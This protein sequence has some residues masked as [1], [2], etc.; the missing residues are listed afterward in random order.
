MPREL[1]S[2]TDFL[3]NHARNIQLNGWPNSKKYQD[4]QDV[5]ITKHNIYIYIYAKFYASWVEMHHN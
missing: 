5:H 4:L 3:A 1:N 2:P